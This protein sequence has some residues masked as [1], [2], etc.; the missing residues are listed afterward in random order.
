VA[1]LAAALRRLAGD[2]ALRAS[3]GAKARERARDFEP[4]AIAQR[5]RAIY[6]ET[7]GR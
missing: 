2:P 5:M 4:A 7:L 1:A 6:D 3:L